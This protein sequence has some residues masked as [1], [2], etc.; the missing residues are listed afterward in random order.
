MPELT[1]SS[2]R[3]VDTEDAAS[4]TASAIC[5]SYIACNRD[6]GSMASRD[7][8]AD[9]ETWAAETSS[10]PRSDTLRLLLS[11]CSWSNCRCNA[12]SPGKPSEAAR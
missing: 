9:C 4:W 7:P 2:V 6:R 1:R 12:R 3:A 5:F 8:A 10:A 11:L